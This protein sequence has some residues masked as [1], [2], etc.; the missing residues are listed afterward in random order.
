[1]E[2]LDNAACIKAY[3]PAF[4]NERR[5]VLIVSNALDRSNGVIQFEDIMSGSGN[6]SWLCDPVR[7]AIYST[8]YSNT[9]IR[10]PDNW[11]LSGGNKRYG[12]FLNN[13]PIRGRV[14]YCLSERQ[15]RGSCQLGASLPIIISVTVCN[16]VKI[17][18]L[19]AT[20]LVAE[21]DLLV[22]T[23]DAV[24]S[25]LS[26]PDANPAHQHIINPENRFWKNRGWLI[27]SD[28][29]IKR[30]KP[31]PKRFFDADDGMRWVI[32]IAP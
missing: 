32:C 10:N 29:V 17:L 31:L 1:M 28:C 5:N 11:T 2:H 20:H 25:F 9:L 14:L 7:S 18:C 15:D 26:V 4:I 22:T 3:Q 21:D 12:S 6:D 27:D 13:G 24:Q 19:I 16:L 23:G 8:C 30:W